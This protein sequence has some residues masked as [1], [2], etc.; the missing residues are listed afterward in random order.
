LHALAHTRGVLMPEEY[1]IQQ[2]QDWVRNELA[3]A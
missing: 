2:F 3:R 1:V